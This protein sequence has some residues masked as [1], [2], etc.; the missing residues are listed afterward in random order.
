MLKNCLAFG[1][2]FVAVADPSAPT[3]VESPGVH[4]KGPAPGLEIGIGRKQIRFVSSS[5]ASVVCVA[6]TFPTRHKLLLCFRVFMVLFVQC[7]LLYLQCSLW[8]T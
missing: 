5:W 6:Y 4:G 7:N 8:I 3:H 1:K 2:P